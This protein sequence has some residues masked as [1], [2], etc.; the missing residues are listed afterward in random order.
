MIRRPPSSTRTASLFPYP[1]ALPISG[2]S[3][4]PLCNFVS[5]KATQ[6]LPRAKP[7]SADRLS[8]STSMGFDAEYALMLNAASAIHVV[9]RMIFFILFLNCSDLLK[10]I[11]MPVSS[12]LNPAIEAINLSKQVVDA[13]GE[14]NILRQKIGRASCRERVC[15]YV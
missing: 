4:F 10:S 14:L 5:S 3:F 1:D 15:Q 12:N 6:P 7:Y 9:V 8:P 11:C 13:S 2:L